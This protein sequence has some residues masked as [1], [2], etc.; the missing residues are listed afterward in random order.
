MTMAARIGDST[1]HGGTI[2]VGFPTVLIGSMPAARIGDSH[3]CPMVTGVVPH[4]GGPIALGAFTVLI[5]GMPAARQTDLA[6]CVGP[7]DLIAIG[8]PNVLIGMAGSGGL[9]GLLKGLALA[10][11]ALLSPAYPR[12]VL[13]GHSI[14]TEY[15]D[16]IT[17]EGT[18]EFQATVLDRLRLIEGTQTGRDMLA[19]IE[20]SDRKMIVV[21]FTGPNSFAGPDPFTWQGLADATPSGQPVFDGSGNLAPAGT[22]A[23]GNGTDTRVQLNPSLQVPNNQDPVQ[24]LPNDAVLFHEMNHGNHMM[25]GDYDGSPQGGGWDTTE[26][27]NTIEDDY[28]SEGDYLQESGYPYRRTDHDSNFTPHPTP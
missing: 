1:V 12:A 20:R 5:G 11:M 18:P 19:G 2:V 9:L 14:V 3:V 17:I 7:P 4:V 16:Q 28:P 26:E 27:R 24:P 15:T 25:N 22:V 6:V 8:Q 21:E 13:R 23:T 10:G